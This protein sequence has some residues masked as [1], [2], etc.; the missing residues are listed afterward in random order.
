MS[1]L[2]LF[3]YR[4]AQGALTLTCDLVGLETESRPGGALMVLEDLPAAA[5]LNLTIRVGVAPG[6]AE[7][8]VPPDEVPEPA[9]RVAAVVRSI[10]SR[11][12]R[13]VDLTQ[14]DAG[15]FRAAVSLPRTALHQ[16]FTV[17]PVLVRAAG[18]PA[19]DGF[20]C[21]TGS[22][23][24]D[25]D[26]VQILLEEPPTPP[27]GYLDVEF[28]D[29]RESGSPLRR[30]RPKVLVAI[31]VTGEFPKLWLNSGIPNLQ[32]VMNTR[33]RRGARARIRDA[34]FQSVTSQVWTSL[35]FMSLGSLASAIEDGVDAQAALD[36]LVDWQK[37]VIHFWAPKIY[38]GLADREQALEEVC[39][40]AA[41]GQVLGELHELAAPAIQ[42]WSGAKTAFDGLTRILTGDGV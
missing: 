37:R 36:E 14:D 22:L 38:P 18:R 5:D 4:Y 2:S 29:F 17:S 11:L 12:R 32:E 34:M 42:E 13:L 24:A 25:G 31:D 3:P 6:T 35:L 33:A 40:S 8:V 30:S 19:V 39:R 9:V 23:L 41:S 16:S 21:H 27:G 1:Q 20:G 10:P 26:P 28:E 7:R 15:G